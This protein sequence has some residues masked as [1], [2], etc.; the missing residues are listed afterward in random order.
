MQVLLLFPFP[1]RE[2]RHIV[3]QISTE[4]RLPGDPKCFGVRR[5]ILLTQVNYAEPTI[6]PRRIHIQQIN[7]ALIIFKVLREETNVT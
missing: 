4:L 1:S 2:S 7:M 3:H 5:Y 6:I